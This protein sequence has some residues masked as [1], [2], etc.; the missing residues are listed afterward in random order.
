MRLALLKTWFGLLVCLTSGAALPLTFD[1]REPTR[2]GRDCTSGA[3]HLQGVIV[4]RDTE[5]LLQVIQRNTSDLKKIG[6]NPEVVGRPIIFLWSEGG[7]VYE[8]IRMGRVI[9]SLGLSTWARDCRSACIFLL[10]GGTTRIAS[11]N[12]FI[13]RPYSNIYPANVTPQDIRR[14]HDEVR[15]T[16]AAYLIEMD[17]SEKLLDTMLAVPPDEY[18]LLTTQE[19]DA[20]RLTGTDSAILESSLVNGAKF[21]GVSLERFREVEGI[22]TRRRAQEYDLHCKN[23]RFASELCRLGLLFG[24]KYD[25]ANS[26]FERAQA[27]DP[28]LS[29][30]QYDACRKKAL[31]P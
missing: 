26:R 7:Q 8:A 24:Y 31:L 15:A 19:M 10:A 5:R 12:V 16:I 25:E 2:S 3:I 9:R 29:V 14:L 4:Q 21:Y 23:Y 17:I 30:S 11:N 6:C 20:F 28:S 1:Y 18:R 22:L 13:H 27:C